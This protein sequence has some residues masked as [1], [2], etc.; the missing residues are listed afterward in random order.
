MF[1]DMVAAILLGARF[2]QAIGRVAPPKRRLRA[3]KLHSY[4]HISCSWR[5][6]VLGSAGAEGELLGRMGEL[7]RMGVSALWRPQLPFGLMAALLCR[8]CEPSSEGGVP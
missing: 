1:G 7:F 5:L 8:K 4:K 3:V 6:F 2:Y